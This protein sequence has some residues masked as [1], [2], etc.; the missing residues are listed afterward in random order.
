MTGQ[1]VAA[2]KAVFAVC[3]YSMKWTMKSAAQIIQEEMSFSFNH[4]GIS[5]SVF[6]ALN[7]LSA[8]VHFP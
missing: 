3:A 7:F 6:F 1:D 5:T 4:M 2:T 8:A